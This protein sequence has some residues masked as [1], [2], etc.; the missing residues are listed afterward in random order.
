[1]FDKRAPW[2]RPT[3]EEIRKRA[4]ILVIDDQDFPY[5]PLFARDDYN[6]TKK[7]DVTNLSELE[8]GSYDLILLDLQGV[9]TKESAD[10]GLGILRHLREVRP[11]QMVIAYSEAMFSLEAQP[12]FKVADG[13]LQKSADY[14]T[15]K[16]KVDELLRARFSLGFYVQRITD[17][18]ALPEKERTQ[19]R[20][21]AEEAILTGK[22]G[23]LTKFLRH[24]VD[25]KTIGRILM[26]IDVA[27]LVASIWK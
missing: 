4:R 5:Q 10:E 16:A 11:A 13:V 3:F 24:N 7:D 18:S 14:L 6:L 12:F 19:L 8:D 17:E 27:M 1:M 23:K 9:G 21:L 2:P 22:I 25:E 26:I 15:F 20:R